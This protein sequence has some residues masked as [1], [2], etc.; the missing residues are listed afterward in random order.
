MSA[1]EIVKSRVAGV[2]SVFEPTLPRTRNVYEPSARS[3][4][5]VW[6]LESE[7]APQLGVPWSTEHWKVAPGL[8]GSALKVHVGVGSSVWPGPLSIVVSGAAASVSISVAS[9]ALFTCVQSAA[10]MPFVPVMFVHAWRRA[11][12]SAP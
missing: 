10:T 2:G 11:F 12:A 6:L 4:E 8:L 3:D 7:Q 5:G 1:V 9:T